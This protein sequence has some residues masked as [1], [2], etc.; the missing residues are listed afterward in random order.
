MRF[1][2]D[3]KVISI[4]FMTG[5]LA[6]AIEPDSSIPFSSVLTQAEFDAYKK[7]PTEE[8]CPAID[9][10]NTYAN[11]LLSQGIIETQPAPVGGEPN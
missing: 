5:A 8:Y 9:D 1:K 7:R 11:Y 3:I 2:F 10:H 6:T 4:C